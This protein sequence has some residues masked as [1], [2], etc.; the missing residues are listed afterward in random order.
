MTFSIQHL[1]ARSARPA[2]KPGTTPKLQDRIT[3]VRRFVQT[4]D[5]RCPI[6]GIWSPIA[7]SSSALDESE[8][9]RPVFRRLHPGRRAI[10]LA[11][12]AV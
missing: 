12:N 9:I 1:F 5:E 10:H 6:A 2:I 4:G 3:L 8:R 11:F 7:E